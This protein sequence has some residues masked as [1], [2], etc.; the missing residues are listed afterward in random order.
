MGLSSKSLS[1]FHGITFQTDETTKNNR[2]LGEIHNEYT[3][4]IRSFDLLGMT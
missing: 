3:R 4:P 1:H 2:N